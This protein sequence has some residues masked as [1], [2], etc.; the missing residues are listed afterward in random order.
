M[1]ADKIRW[2]Q[3][4][5]AEVAKEDLYDPYSY[6]K[7]A[8]V[9]RC[10]ES[11]EAYAVTPLVSLSG[12]ASKGGV[13]AVFVKDESHRFGLKAFKGLGGTY[14]MY[15]M[16][17]KELGL[18]PAETGFADL[19]KE[20]HA[21]KIRDLVFITTTDG[22][23]GKGVSWAAKLFG[24]KAYVFM[25]V[26]TVEVRAQAIRDAGNAE[27]TITDMPYDACVNYTAV[28]AEE[29]GW[30]LIQDTSWDGYE[31]VPLWIMQGYTTLFSECMM[32][33]KEAGYSGPTHIF[34]Q[35]GVGAMAGAVAGAAMS[36]LS[37]AGPV[38]STVEPKEVA[39]F[40]ESALC[41]DGKPHAATGTQKTIMAGLN[42]A[43]PCTLAWDVIK[44]CASYAFAC[45]DA[46][47]EH[48][49]RLLADP[50]TGDSPVVAGESGAVTTGLLDHLLNDPKYAELR[51]EMELN[52]NAVVLLINTEGDTD[53]DNYQK[54]L[55]VER[56]G[57][58]GV[59]Y[60]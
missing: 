36:A 22:N 16:I 8:P 4:P 32:Q 47:T 6:E 26:G 25:P 39:C 57:E 10:H 33:L 40:Y 43:S 18:D 12:L 31:D 9:R 14:A 55:A 21:S 48:G 19:L 5:A 34:L 41:G 54:V 2:L 44:H 42:C 13:K 3:F 49:M 58:N 37:D 27:V 23:H 35:A 7:T 24:C 11:L 15:R 38:I 20:P 29:N 1:L 50:A 56:Y 59:S 28:L 46:V 51:Q 45:N 17:C 30:L 60:N 53:P 52:E